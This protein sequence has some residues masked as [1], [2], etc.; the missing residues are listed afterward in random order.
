LNDQPI[1]YGL[2][3]V[4]LSCADYIKRRL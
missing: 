3:N 2:S 1:L 4:G